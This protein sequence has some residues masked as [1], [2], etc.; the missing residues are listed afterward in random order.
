[1][2]RDLNKI[3]NKFFKDPENGGGN[4]W[5]LTYLETS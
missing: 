3:I 1:V 4:K 2:F 5:V